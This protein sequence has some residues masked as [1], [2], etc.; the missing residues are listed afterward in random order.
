M[1][2]IVAGLLVV[3]SAG[4]TT[5]V[6]AQTDSARVVARMQ[7][8]AGYLKT[9]PVDSVAG[10]FANDGQLI[11]PGMDPVKTPAGI[12]GFLTPLVAQFTVDSCTMTAEKVELFGT[13]ALEWGDY[14]QRAGPK[15][16]QMAD[17]HGRFV[18]ELRR[19]G[20]GD[21]KIERLFMQPAPP[22]S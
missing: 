10:S 22:G 20:D 17:Y 12:Q 13:S 8:Y 11:S 16:G 4:V 2:K 18:A 3:W 9:G 15:N 1:R 5:K 21:W 14:T 7:S 6:L 19:Q